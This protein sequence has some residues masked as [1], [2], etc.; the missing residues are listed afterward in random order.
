MALPTPVVVHD[1]PTI[2]LGGQ[3]WPVP[4]LA[5]R[6][7]RVLQPLF[8]RVTGKIME[9]CSLGELTE[10]D[11][12][13]LVQI[14]YTALTRAHPDLS[15]TDFEEMPIS[16]VQLVGAIPV[17]MQQSGLYKPPQAG[18]GEAQGEASPPIGTAS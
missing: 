7:N 5:L 11:I 16:L 6:Q 4:V 1:C 2:S 9:G 17:V 13:A 18:A 14:S 15:R 12:E 3:D 8:N 10:A